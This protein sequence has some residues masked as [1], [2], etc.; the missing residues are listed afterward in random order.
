MPATAFAKVFGCAA[1]ALVIAVAGVRVPASRDG[2]HD[3]R[4]QGRAQDRW[5]AVVA[6][7]AG[8]PGDAMMVH[9][10]TGFAPVLARVIPA[11]VTL[12]VTS[13]VAIPSELIVA[14]DGG[15]S[16]LAPPRRERTRSGGSGV[17]IDA[18]NGHIV[19]NE[20]VVRD[21]VHIDVM[22][23]DGRMY[24]AQVLGSDVSTDVA[25]LAIKAA[26]LPSVAVGDS[27]KVRV[28]DVAL[29][30][31]NP[32]GLEGTAT[33]GIV[34]ALMRSQ[35]GHGL[36]EDFMQIDA[37]IN[38][39]N[40]GGALVNIQGELIGI[41]TAGPGE[42]GRAS[43]IGFAIPINIARAVK[44]EI[45]KHGKFSRGSTGLVVEDL[46]RERVE[47]LDMRITR[48]AVVVG[49]VPGSPAAD[50][51]IAPG[52]IVTSVAGKPVRNAAEFA[53]RVAIQTLGSQF[54][55]RVYDQGRERTVTLRSAALKA[56]VRA[57]V[58]GE[59]FGALAGLAVSEIGPG[60]RLSGRSSGIVVTSVGTGT[61]A[62]H[63]GLEAGD[64]IVS[65]DASSPRSIDDFVRLVQKAGF[66]YRVTVVRDGQ[67]AWVR[68]AR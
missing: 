5:A 31:G 47:S 24:P 20:H 7:A 46:S 19:T 33:M 34:S 23:A 38:P 26:N 25:I 57:E 15:R 63:L 53:N 35:V 17:V 1:I 4:I 3:L 65:V 40:S 18:Q 62:R 66:E 10:Q 2:S 12:L 41:N 43:G 21:S 13:E 39:G 58:L 14:T 42:A 54:E 55:V 36:V 27:D 30:V 48:G 50:A 16:T 44:T 49:T 37:A 61:P 29:A 59:R 56:P 9:A 22:L 6:E 28:G 60:E 52:S 68:V 8:K 32:F 11:V 67:P 51:G 64:V 45:L